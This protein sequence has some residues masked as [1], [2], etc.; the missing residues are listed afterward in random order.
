METSPEKPEDDLETLVAEALD[1][2]LT[3]EWHA[4]RLRLSVTPPAAPQSNRIVLR[5]L[6]SVV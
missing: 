2:V 6:R 5:P 1:A 3:V 4:G